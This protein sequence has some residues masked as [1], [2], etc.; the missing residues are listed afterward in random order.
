MVL[1]EAE[2]EVRHNDYKK[3]LEIDTSIDKT[4]VHA[5][6]THSALNQTNAGDAKS[7]YV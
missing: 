3:N 2:E 6:D 7:E 5:D 1:S 4:Q